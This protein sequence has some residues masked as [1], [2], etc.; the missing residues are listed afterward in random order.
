[1]PAPGV[2]VKLVPVDEKLEVRYRPQCDAGYWRQSELSEEAFDEEGYFAAGMPPVSLMTQF[3]RKVA[4]RW[5]I[6]EDFKL[7]SGRG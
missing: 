7:L 6:A 5:R 2:T 4:L 1:L 3:P